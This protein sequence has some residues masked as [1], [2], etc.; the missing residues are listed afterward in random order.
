MDNE[1]VDQRISFIEAM[2]RHDWSKWKISI[3]RKY[4]LLI[5]TV[6]GS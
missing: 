3:E 5:E 2:A 1:R 6:L 4:N